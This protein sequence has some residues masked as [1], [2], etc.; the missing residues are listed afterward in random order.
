[1]S[2]RWSARFPTTCSGEM[3]LG[4]PMITPVWVRVSLER[5]RAMP[6]SAIFARPSGVI[7]MLAGLNV[8]MHDLVLGGRRRDPR[9]DLGGDVD[10][11]ARPEAIA[12]GE[13]L[14]QLAALDVLHGHVHQVSALSDVRR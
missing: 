9:D 10:Q 11:P 1:M 8:P 5:M 13:Q 3:Y 14:A 2:E 6:K 4:E 12:L 7:M